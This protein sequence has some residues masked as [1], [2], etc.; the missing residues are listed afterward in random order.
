MG[1]LVKMGK[2]SDR[3]Y[4]DFKLNQLGYDFMGYYFDNRKELSYHHIKPTH[5]G[6]ETTYDNGA[7][8]VRSTSHNYI[9]TIEEYDYK[10]FLMVTRLLFEEKYM[11]KVD[12]DILKEI[13]SILNC[14]ESKY[15]GIYTKK[16]Q[17]LVREEFTRRRKYDI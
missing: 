11:G 8:L 14:F 7:L 6:G 15:N 5:S 4:Y 1:G 3:L 17:P 10:M 2:L 16:G 13:D 12:T 9:H